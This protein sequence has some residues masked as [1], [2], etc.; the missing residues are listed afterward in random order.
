MV[1]LVKIGI[2]L[3]VIIGIPM[4]AILSISIQSQNNIPNVEI[5]KEVIYLKKIVYIDTGNLY[6]EAI[7]HIKEYEGFRSKIYYDTDGS[8]TIGYG[9]HLKKSEKFANI[10]ESFA[11]NLLIK[12]LNKKIK[13]VEETTELS[14]NKSL[15]LGMFAFN[16]GNSNLNKAIKNG[17]LKNINKLKLYCNYTTTLN[18]EKITKSSLKLLERRKFEIYIYTYNLQ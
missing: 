12:D 3:I 10:S 14:N 8:K 15:A 13:Y 16:V 6:N 4:L 11:T 18:G 5:V 17:L 7:K 9:H 1:K 2:N